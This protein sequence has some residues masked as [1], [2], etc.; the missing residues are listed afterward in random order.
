MLKELWPQN[1]KTKI[2]KNIKFLNNKYLIFAKIF[3]QLI[4][5]NSKLMVPIYFWYYW[6]SRCKTH[7]RDEPRTILHRLC[8]ILYKRS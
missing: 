8:F 3:L 1:I 2:E 7:I 5:F 6:Q 4:A